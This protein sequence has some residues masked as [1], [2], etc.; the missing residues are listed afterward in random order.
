MLLEREG[1]LF[2]DDARV[3][4][5]ACLWSGQEPTLADASSS[6]PTEPPEGFDWELELGEYN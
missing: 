1:V 6:F 3:D 4:L 5:E 2:V